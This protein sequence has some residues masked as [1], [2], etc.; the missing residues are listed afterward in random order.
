MN[1]KF[2]SAAVGIIC[3]IALPLCGAENAKVPTR[4]DT[5]RNPATAP[6][7]QKMP[8][9]NFMGIRHDAMR[10]VILIDGSGSMVP[11]FDQIKEELRRSVDGLLPAQSINII[12]FKDDG[13]VALSEREVEAVP[14][15]K[16]KAYDFIDRAAVHSASDPAKGLQAAFAGEPQV[17]YLLTNGDFPNNGK[18]LQQV[19]GLNKDKK[20]SINSI[21]FLEH[22]AEYEKFLK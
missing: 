15:N 4:G 21:A 12:L 20:V 22:G 13:Y 10:M 6:S 9:T 7:T 5:P 16:M 2:A 14:L 19:R 17:I 3:A 11:N 1:L 8:P 18:V